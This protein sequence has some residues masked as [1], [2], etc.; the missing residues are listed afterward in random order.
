VTTDRLSRFLK[1]VATDREAGHIQ[2]RLSSCKSSFSQL[3][4]IRATSPSR[5]N[6]TLGNRRM[7]RHDRCDK[8]KQTS[9]YQ[10]SMQLLTLL[11]SR[12][13]VCL[14]SGYLAIPIREDVDFRARQVARSI[15]RKTITCVICPP[16]E[17]SRGTE[18]E[19]ERERE[20][21]LPSPGN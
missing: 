4:V 18:R 8:P 19:R 1:R 13:F 16:R 20:K 21:A 5:V 12:A 2:L 9:H 15:Q 7:T 10:S 6:F 17:R 14:R 11:T 3:R